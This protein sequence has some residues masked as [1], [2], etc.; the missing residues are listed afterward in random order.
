M[1]ILWGVLLIVTASVVGITAN[2]HHAQKVAQQ[3]AGLKATMDSLCV[4]APVSGED[5]QVHLLLCSP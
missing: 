5:L 2:V 1:P 3:N 4:A